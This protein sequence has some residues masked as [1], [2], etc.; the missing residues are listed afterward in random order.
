[1][2]NLMFILDFIVCSIGLV[3]VSIGFLLSVFSKL[4]V[5]IG[6]LFEKSG[7]AIIEVIDKGNHHDP[8]K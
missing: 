1:M 4:G 2:K 7:L 8:R 6:D 5:T 3:L